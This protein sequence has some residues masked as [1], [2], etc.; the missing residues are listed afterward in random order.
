MLREAL[1]Q[2]KRRQLARALGQACSEGDASSNAEV[3]S[4]GRIFSP[5]KSRRSASTED[6]K[7]P[8]VSTAGRLLTLG[9][10]LQILR[11]ITVS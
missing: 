4:P 5:G 3:G 11:S 7:T 10:L 1:E 2:E 6:A 9:A 8:G